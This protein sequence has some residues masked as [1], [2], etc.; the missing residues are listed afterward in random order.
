MANKRDKKREK[1]LIK[2]MKIVGSLCEVVRTEEE[3][4]K[5]AGYSDEDIAEL[6][7]K[8]GEGF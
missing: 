4:L 8:S 7:E 6:E 2:L 3:L 1:N 5:R